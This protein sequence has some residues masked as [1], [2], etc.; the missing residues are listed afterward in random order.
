[1]PRYGSA[2]S[3]QRLSPDLVHPDC[4]LRRRRQQGI[5]PPRRARAPH[6][7]GFSRGESSIVFEQLKG[8][9]RPSAFLLS[10]AAACKA[11]PSD[12]SAPA[13]GCA[14]LQQVLRPPTRRQST[15]S[16]PQIHLIRAPPFWR[17]PVLAPA[18]WHT[19]NITHSLP[20]PFLFSNIY[21]PI[22][23]ALSVC[24]TSQLV[25]LAPKRLPRRKTTL[26]FGSVSLRP[27]PLT[28]YS[29]P[30]VHSHH[31]TKHHDVHIAYRSRFDIFFT[32]IL[33]RG[34]R[35]TFKPLLVLS[36]D[37]SSLPACSTKLLPVGS[38]G[39]RHVRFLG[40]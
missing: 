29:K 34:R 37:M 22:L 26:V 8:F 28:C 20:P 1:M 31:T 23:S 14:A 17:P 39:N 10:D 21:S 33:S 24:P 30:R 25:R 3:A 4:R 11:E 19:Y 6:S 5:Y 12:T 13:I 2:L 9:V 32:T 27:G 16:T 40:P 18:T 36:S 15:G 7:P 38:T 35:K